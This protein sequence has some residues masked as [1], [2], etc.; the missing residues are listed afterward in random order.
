MSNILFKNTHAHILYKLTHASQDKMVAVKK[1]IKKIRI[2]EISYQE[3]IS[4]EVSLSKK[5]FFFSKL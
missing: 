3:K 4:T 5:I 2:S 1:K